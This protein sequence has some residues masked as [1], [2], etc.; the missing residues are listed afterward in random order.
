M[1]VIKDENTLILVFIMCVLAFVSGAAAGIVALY[2]AG[3]GC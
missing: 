3:R 2:V 1:Q